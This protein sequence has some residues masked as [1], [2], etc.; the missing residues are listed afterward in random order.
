[1]RR[2]LR[3]TQTLFGRAGLIITSALLLFSL[4]AV[5]I[6]ILLILRPME[7]QAAEDLAAFIVLS[8]MTWV[9]LPPLTR[10]D[11]EWEMQHTHRIRIFE[12]ADELPVK[13]A[14]K[15]YLRALSRALSYRLG[16]D[17]HLHQMPE[18]SDWL[19]VDVPI[20]DRVLR[21]GFEADR[22]AA[23]VPLAVVLNV[24]F[25]LLIVVLASLV[26]VRNMTKPLAMMA[27]ATATVGRAANH[28]PVPETGPHEVAELARSFNRMDTQIRELL[29]SR[30][31]LLAGI[32]HDLRTPIAR[33]RLALELLPGDSEAGLEQGIL[34]DLE[35][36]DNLIG[37]SLEL[38]R[39]VR[40]QHA[41]TVDLEV[42]LDALIA[43][44]SRADVE[45]VLKAQPGLS[46]RL[47]ADSLRR[48]IVNLLDNAERYSAGETVDL[49]CFND[50]E[51]IVFV[52][53]DRGPGI[54]E[55]CRSRAFEPFWRLE[56]SRSQATGGSG[57][58][59]AIVKQI[60]DANGW[61]IRL[62]ESKY[63]GL[64]VRLRVPNAGDTS[65]QHVL[66]GDSPSAGAETS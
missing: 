11:F 64:E 58:G 44:Y 50:N 63:G 45:V 15:S 46:A 32:S 9:E 35:E 19:W 43:D 28:V 2:V 56:S 22:I 37:Q 49:H 61:D 10:S 8:A 23:Q 38:A 60:C 4:F 62:G 14:D 36:M 42:F 53:A 3:H 18:Q 7:E 29:A 13:V 48:V 12:A 55:D 1:M 17:V 24:L 54:P 20:A 41:T 27:Q 52:V 30:T 57:L 59:L 40:R 5:V 21:I 39:G 25:G 16:D 51:A 34:D 6:N 66:P 26:M 65:E 33:M 47:P 31:T